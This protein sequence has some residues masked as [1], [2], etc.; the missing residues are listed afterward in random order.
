MLSLCACSRHND[1]TL[2]P[3]TDALVEE[4]VM[5]L[6]EAADCIGKYMQNVDV[7]SWTRNGELDEFGEETQLLSDF[8]YET[9]LCLS[10]AGLSNEDLAEIKEE[11]GDYAL[12]AIGLWILDQENVNAGVDRTRSNVANCLLQALGGDLFASVGSTLG[13]SWKMVS[14]KAIKVAVKQAAK[15]FIGPVG[16]LIAVGEFTLCMA[17]N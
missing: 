13:V 5:K 6:S 3:V 7:A 8:I 2:D 11:C 15:Y 17:T 9:E 14:K 4:Q 1:S 16:A 12:T 10:C